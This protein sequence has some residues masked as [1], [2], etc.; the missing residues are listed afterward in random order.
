MWINSYLCRKDELP[1]IPPTD[2]ILLQVLRAEYE[3]II[4]LRKYRDFFYI[5]VPDMTENNIVNNAQ[6]VNIVK[7]KQDHNPTIINTKIDNSIATLK[8]SMVLQ[9]ESSQTKKMQLMLKKRRLN[10]IVAESNQV[11]NV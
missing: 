11:D 6:G 5:Y 10:A 4:E 2:N 9:H 3:V 1:I 7:D 8:G